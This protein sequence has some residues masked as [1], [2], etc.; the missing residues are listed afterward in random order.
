MM[1]DLRAALTAARPVATRMIRLVG[2]VGRAVLLSTRQYIVLIRLVVATL[3]RVPLFVQSRPL[4]DIRA[5]VQI[6]EVVRD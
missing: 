6:V 1:A 3:H 2:E 5:D 4:K